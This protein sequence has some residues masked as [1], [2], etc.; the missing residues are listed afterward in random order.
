MSSV[1]GFGSLRCQITEH[2]HSHFP[3]CYEVHM[4]DGPVQCTQ[5]TLTMVLNSSQAKTTELQYRPMCCSYD[6]QIQHF[7]LCVPSLIHYTWIFIVRVTQV[8][9]L[10]WP[11]IVRIH[12]THVRYFY[13]FLLLGAAAKNW[14][15][16]EVISGIM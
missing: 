5:L 16:P 6:L 15:T 11:F 2:D 4:C 9:K 7:N 8:A 1:Y 3:S 13:S 14:S 10:T 12:R